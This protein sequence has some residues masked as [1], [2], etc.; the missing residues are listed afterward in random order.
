M[1]SEPIFRVVRASLLTVMHDDDFDV[2]AGEDGALD[3]STDHWT[4]HLEDG[5]GF[6]AIDDEPEEPAQ[7][8][9]ARRKAITERVERAL[10]FADRELDGAISTALAA[11]GDPFTLDFVAALSRH[12]VDN[13]SS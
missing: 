9:A 10:A 7:F 6:L 8:A 12:Q 2:A 4:V 11:S 1:D 3:I 5:I 13:P